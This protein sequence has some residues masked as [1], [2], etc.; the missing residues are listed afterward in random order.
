MHVLEVMSFNQYWTAPQF[1]QKKPYL[2]GSLQQA[3]G[4]NIYFKDDDGNW[5]QQDSHHSFD[6]GIPNQKNVSH[7]TQTDR[8]L[9]SNNFAYWGGSGPEIPVMFRNFNGI[10]IRARRGHK[11]PIFTNEFVNAFIRWIHGINECGFL[12]EPLDWPDTL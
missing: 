11:N 8:V 7:D 3:Y 5:H 2:K 6:H 4:D 12:G 9:I 10:D 1:R